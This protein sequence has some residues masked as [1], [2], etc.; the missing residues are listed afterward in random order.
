VKPNSKDSGTKGKFVPFC[1]HCG[2]VGHIRP[3]CFLLKSH[4]TWKKQEDS[5]N[6]IIEKTSSDKYVT[7]HRRHIS[8]EVRTL[9]FVKM[10]IL[11]LQSPSRNIS[12][13]KVSLPAFTVVSLDTSG[14]T[15]LRFDISSLGS[16]NQ[17]KR[18]VSLALSLLSL[19]MLFGNNGI[20]FKGVLPLAVNVVSMATPRPNASK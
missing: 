15:I 17:S 18:Q 20:I 1:H 2:K 9:L 8:Q 16:G 13:N 3:K 5:R 14:H 12:V 4:G 19:I 7:P 10:L 11:N 6:G